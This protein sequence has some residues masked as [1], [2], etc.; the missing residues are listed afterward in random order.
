MYEYLNGK[1]AYKCPTYV[2]LD[3][4]G[5]GY[6]VN[7][8]LYT[9]GK[10]KDCEQ[11][12]LYVSFQVKEDAHSLYGFAEEGERKLFNHLLS[13]SGIGAS[14]GRMILS[15][16]TPTEIQTAIV[17]GDVKQIQRIKGI[18][19]KSAQRIILELQD[20]LKKEGADTLISVPQHQSVPEEALTALV[21]L[22]FN[23]AQAEK[24]LTEIQKNNAAQF[25][26]EELIKEALRRL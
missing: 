9:F 10:I 1:L 13:V 17:Q 24:V 25:T 11:C 15:S 2:V 8:S 18:G 22:G 23:K 5:V 21:M 6:H 3:V 14:T 20:K 12:K 16:I 4:N 19:P 26:V 7:I